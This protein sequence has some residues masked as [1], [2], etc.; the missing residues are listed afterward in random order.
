MGIDPRSPGGQGLTRTP[1]LLKEDFVEE[2]CCSKIDKAKEKESSTKPIRG[3]AAFVEKLQE[4]SEIEDLLKSTSKMEIS[5]ENEVAATESKTPSEE[6]NQTEN[7]N[8]ENIETNESCNEEKENTVS[9]IT[10]DKETDGTLSTP[11]SNRCGKKTMFPMVIGYEEAKS[12][13]SPLGQLNLNSKFMASPVN[14]NSKSLSGS[15]DCSN[16]AIQAQV[17]T[18]KKSLGENME[19]VD[20]ENQND[21]NRSL[22][23]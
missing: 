14:S 16:N 21:T 19:E 8:D 6:V 17:P 18:P 3:S 12:P 20:Q 15:G 10:I 4:T 1:I 23:I 7:E 11:S 22:V 9:G 5:T 13:R 2:K